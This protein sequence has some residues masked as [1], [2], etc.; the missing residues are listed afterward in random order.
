MNAS[1]PSASSLI[2]AKLGIVAGGGNVPRSLIAACQKLGRPFYVVC[3]EGQ[4]DQDLAANL[5][6]IWLPLG[7]ASK[8]KALVTEQNITELVMIGRV[9]R[10]SM[11]EIKPDWLALK[12]LTKIGMTMLGDDALLSAIGKAMEDEGIKV[13]SAQDI[14]ADVLTPTGQLGSIAPDTEAQR[15]IARGLEVATALGRLDIGQSVVVQQGMI[16][17]VEAIEGTDALIARCGP[18]RRQGVGGVL[19]KIAKPQQDNRYDLPT[20]GPDTIAALIAAGLRGVVLEAGRSLLVDRER[21]IA[22]ADA[23]GLFISGIDLPHADA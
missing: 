15:D 2:T 12:V 16:L 22:M 10:P 9:R 8:L 21:A 7:A 13:I 11:L 4:A 14:F 3:L 20:V 18:L 5:P 19:V 1:S 23:A 17:G 6:H